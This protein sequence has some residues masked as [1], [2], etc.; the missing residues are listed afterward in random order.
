MGSMDD[1]KSNKLSYLKRSEYLAKWVLTKVGSDIVE[2]FKVCGGE[3]PKE[4]VPKKP[5]KGRKVREKQL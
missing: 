2:D 4:L 1:W 3:L 5:Q